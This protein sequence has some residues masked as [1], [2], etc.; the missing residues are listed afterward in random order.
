MSAETSQAAGEGSPARLMLTLGVLGLMSGLLLAVSYEATL[1]AIEAWQ[2][3]T[4]QEAVFRVVPGTSRL[5]PLMAGEGGLRAVSLDEAAA[6]D[7]VFAAYDEQGAFRGYGIPAAGAGFQDTI[8][9]IY[10]LDPAGRRLVGMNILESRETPGLGDKIFK[11]LAFVGRFSDL[12]I[13]PTIAPV[14]KGEADAPNEVDCITGATIS[15]KAVIRIIN[16]SNARWLERL[17]VGDQVPAWSPPPE[18]SGEGAPAPGG[19]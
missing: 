14:K 5:L 9:L 8:R 18:K 11:D 4:L 1:P 16:E 10:G 17:P 2:R 15:S 19:Q 7:A 12:P 6:G 3:K 13:D